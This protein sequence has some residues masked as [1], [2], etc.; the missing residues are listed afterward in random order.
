MPAV[1]RVNS[2]PPLLDW[3]PLSPELLSRVEVQLTAYAP[4]LLGYSCGKVYVVPLAPPVRVSVSLFLS[5]H[6]ITSLNVQP[7]VSPLLTRRSF[8]SRSELAHDDE[9]L[10]QHSFGLLAAAC[11]AAAGAA[12]TALDPCGGAA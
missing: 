8:T 7:V 11:W 12:I 1:M 6:L 2:S 4:G 5:P 9:A 3:Q 10:F